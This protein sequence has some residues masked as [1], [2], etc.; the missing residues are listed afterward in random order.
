VP[1]SVDVGRVHETASTTRCHSR[2][3]RLRT[4]TGES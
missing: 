4:A 2:S 3:T 1:I